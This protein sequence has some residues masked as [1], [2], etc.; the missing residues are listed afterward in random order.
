MNRDELKAKLHEAEIQRLASSNKTQYPS[1]MQMARNLGGSVVRNAMSVAAGNSLRLDEGAAQ[2]RLNICK[3]C[4]FFNQTQ[5][6]CGKCGCNMAVKTYL[7]AE[8][9]P[10]GKW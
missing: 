2:S 8:K 1:A 5:E 7:R 4:E 10:L 6:R 3:G 9:C